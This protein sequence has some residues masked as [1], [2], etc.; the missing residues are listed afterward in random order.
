M[1]LTTLQRLQDELTAGDRLFDAILS[2]FALLALLLAV[3]GAYGVVRLNAAQRTAEFGI[4]I[5]L[6]ATKRH[7]IQ[8]IAKQALRIAGTGALLGS[9]ISFSL[10]MLL[11][12]AFEGF[13]EGLSLVFAVIPAAVVSVCL[14]AS[15]VPAYRTSRLDP[16]IS[17]RAE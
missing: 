10:P 13:H 17:M 7:V 9:V 4:R 5:A 14:L 6:G 11:S 16:L 12:S 15:L 8:T 3:I 2:L 1:N